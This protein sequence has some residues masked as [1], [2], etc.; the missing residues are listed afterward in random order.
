LNPLAALDAP[1]REGLT[2]VDA[3][4]PGSGF[5]DLTAGARGDASGVAAFAR[6]EAGWHFAPSGSAFAFGEALLGPGAGPS[7]QAGVGVRATW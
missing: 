5:L 1:I 6:G 3:L 2:K 7:W 4:K